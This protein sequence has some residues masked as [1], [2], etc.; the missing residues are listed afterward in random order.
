MEYVIHSRSSA[1]LIRPCL[2]GIEP[3]GMVRAKEVHSESQMVMSF[4]AKQ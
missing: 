2:Q 1:T 4:V 3:R